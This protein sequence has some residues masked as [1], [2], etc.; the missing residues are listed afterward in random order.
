MPL[1]KPVKL[2]VRLPVVVAPSII[3]VFPMVGLIVV[4]QQTPL[5]IILEK[6]VGIVAVYLA[7]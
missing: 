3:L 4:F 2:A 5:C 1:V 7:V 6:L